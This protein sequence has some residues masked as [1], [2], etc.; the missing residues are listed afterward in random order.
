V[1][2]RFPLVTFMK[3]HRFFRF[4]FLLLFSFTAPVLAQ[5]EHSGA[6]VDLNFQK[7][8]PEKN[9]GTAG[10][11]VEIASEGP[12]PPEHIP[13]SQ[14]EEGGVRFTPGGRKGTAIQV[15]AGDTLRLS[16]PGE[17]ITL[18]V[19]VRLPD[20]AD[21]A[22]TRGKQSL[23]SSLDPKETGG[24]MFGVYPNGS[25]F[26]YWSRAEASPAIRGTET[27]VTHGKWHHIAVT[28]TN[29]ES[30]GL[31]FF[32][33]GVPADPKVGPKTLRVKGTQPIPP[34]EEP[35]SIGATG[36][37]RYPFRG[38]IR[39]LQ[40]YDKAL[41]EDEIARLARQGS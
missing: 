39:S 24:W 3:P 17:E 16:S 10:G 28:W 21:S 30:G 18:S 26:F 34:S 4:L 2:P 31:Q 20:P 36:D 37:G 29:D 5:A 35:I 41:G 27:L 22:D 1:P 13:G 12:H 11:T 38:E 23:V 8:L 15:D 25:V 19:W 7:E 40:I 32:V 14:A 6:A 33:D 9:A